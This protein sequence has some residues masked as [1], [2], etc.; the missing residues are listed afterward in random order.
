[1][2]A[3]MYATAIGA[4]I[5]ALFLG[6]LFIRGYTVK[7][8]EGTLEEEKEMRIESGFY[9]KQYE[10][11]V[12]NYSKLDPLG[13]KIAQI[14][15]LLDLNDISD[16]TLWQTIYTKGQKLYKL[17]NKISNEKEKEDFQD[18]KDQYK[19]FFKFRLSS[20]IEKSALFILDIIDS[21]KVISKDLYDLFYVNYFETNNEFVEALETSKSELLKLLKMKH[22]IDKKARADAS[23]EIEYDIVQ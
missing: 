2:S 9:N 21:M 15:D 16:E 11:T 3:A 5:F 13:Q 12:E 23:F 7:Y 14:I 17:R 19:T 6:Y 10:K 1:M 18:Y 22:T 8:G 4:N 20:N